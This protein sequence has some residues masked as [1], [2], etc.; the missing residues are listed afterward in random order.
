MPPLWT[1]KRNHHDCAAG[2]DTNRD[3]TMTTGTSFVDALAILANQSD[4]PA[5]YLNT[6]D[7]PH[8]WA[9]QPQRPQGGYGAQGGRRG[10]TYAPNRETR[11]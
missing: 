3:R 9:H 11:L 6:E 5:D 2:H 1:Q 4:H 8:E 10:P 7:H